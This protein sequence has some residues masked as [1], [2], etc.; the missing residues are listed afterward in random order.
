LGLSLAASLFVVPMLVILSPDTVLAIVA[1][2]TTEW[3]YVTV[4]WLG[5]ALALAITVWVI[6]TGGAAADAQSVGSY[7]FYYLACYLVVFA[8]L[9]IIATPSGIGMRSAAGRTTYSA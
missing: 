8:A 2:G 6:E 1:G 3:G 9:W 7:P 4:V 5:L